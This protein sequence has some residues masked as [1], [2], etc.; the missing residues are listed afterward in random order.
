[1]ILQGERIVIKKVSS[2]ENKDF[3]L[4]VGTQMITKGLDLKMFNW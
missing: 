2:F 1:M 4:M 3:D